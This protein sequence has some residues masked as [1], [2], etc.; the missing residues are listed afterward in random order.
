MFAA[1]KSRPRIAEEH[2]S[3]TSLIAAVEA[4]GGV[5][6]V[7]QPLACIAGT[8][9]R[10]IPLSPAPNPLFIGAAW[11]KGGLAMAAERF[12]RYSKEIALKK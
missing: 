1:I 2:D 9:L 7:S 3:V 8:R 12:L 5:A 4:G 11:A 6:L 10:L